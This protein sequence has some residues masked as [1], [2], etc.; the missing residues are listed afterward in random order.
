MNPENS[1]Q[2]QGNAPVQSSPLNTQ[3]PSAQKAPKHGNKKVFVIGFIVILLILA[4]LGGGY[5]LGVSKTSQPT[6]TPA[7]IA[8]EPTP[9]PDPM[10]DWKIYKNTKYSYSFNYP[11]KYK[12]YSGETDA[13]V[14]TED[15]VLIDKEIQEGESY[16]IF[17]VIYL[18]TN[19]NPKGQ[20]NMDGF[21]QNYKKYL[22]TKVGDQVSPP[23]QSFQTKFTRKQDEIVGGT[24]G[25]VFEGTV[26]NG[27]SENS[28]IDRRIIVSNANNPFIL[29]TYYFTKAGE[30][31]QRQILSTFKFTK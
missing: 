8:V 31:T 2:P 5:Y 23:N 12:A 10:A 13:V 1:Q 6:S 18:G 25:I 15:A 3:Q 26:G 20:Y 9:I 19:A 21:S 24:T 16:P 29:G 27:A 22:S 28:L 30:E 14:G 17:Y 4:I 11:Q 7:P